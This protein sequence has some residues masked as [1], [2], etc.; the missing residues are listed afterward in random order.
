MAIVQTNRIKS[1]EVCVHGC[2]AGLS[3]LFNRDLIASLRS[4]DSHLSLNTW[5]WTVELNGHCYLRV[6]RWYDLLVDLSQPG[7]TESARNRSLSRDRRYKDCEKDNWN[8]RIHCY[9]LV[10]GCWSKPERAKE[11][12][13]RQQRRPILLIRSFWSISTNWCSGANYSVLITLFSCWVILWPRVTLLTTWF[14]W[15]FLKISGIELL[16]W[17]ECYADF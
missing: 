15:S 16:F 8:S 3:C 1:I 13:R 17:M 2:S 9:V 6:R 7:N 10:S 11:K 5:R 14:F 12:R 4:L